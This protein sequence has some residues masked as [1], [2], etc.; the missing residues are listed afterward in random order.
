MPTPADAVAILRTIAGLPAPIVESAVQLVE[1]LLGEPLKVVG[2]AIADQVEMWKWQNRVRMA[3]RAREIIEEEAVATRVVPPAF[4]L[5]V[6]EAAG[7]A[8]HPTL[9]EMWAQLTAS[10]VKDDAAQQPIF[11]RLLRDLSPASAAEFARCCSDP[12]CWAHRFDLRSD[13]VVFVGG[14]PPVTVE[15]AYLLSLG[16]VVWYASTMDERTLRFIGPSV[17]GYHFGRAV[18]PR[19]AAWSE[20]RA[21]KAPGPRTL[22]YS[23]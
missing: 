21:P 5:P 11:T 10:G 3:A 6:I 4:L 20:W 19:L 9:L 23:K 16:L 13:S 18:M 2:A 15:E 7:Y 12:A 22:R 17:V 1:S 8:D 14:P